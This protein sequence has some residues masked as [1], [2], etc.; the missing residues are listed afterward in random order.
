MCIRDSGRYVPVRAEVMQDNEFS[1]HGDCSDLLDWM[2]ALTPTPTNVFTVHGTA[3]AAATFGRRISERLGC[4]SVV[5][6]LGE[7]VRID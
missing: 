6:T 4:L 5:P 1:V 7:T 3:E 2:A